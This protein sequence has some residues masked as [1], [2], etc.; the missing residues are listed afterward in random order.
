MIR[1][2]IDLV[3]LAIIALCTWGGYKR[4]LIGG[5]AGL[6]AIVIS[7]FCANLVS[8]AYSGEVIPALEPF[9]DGYL[10]SAENR[11]KILENMGYGDSDYS[12]NDILISDPSMRYDYAYECMSMMGFHEDRAESL[13]KRSVELSDSQDILMPEATVSIVCDTVTY[14]GGLIIAFLLIL[15]LIVAIANIG[16]LS[17]RLPNMENLDEIGGAILGFAKGFLYCTL[18]CWSL[19]FLGLIIGKTTVSKT[20]LANFFLAFD[21]LT[22]GLV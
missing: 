15:I 2:I 19:S 5:I 14:V 13:A 22:K 8:N 16:N 3:L 21:F 7:L 10:N 4:G 6:L 9:V 18:L 11:E 20:V 17:F 12:L 1:L